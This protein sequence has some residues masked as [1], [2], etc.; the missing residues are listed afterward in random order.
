MVIGIISAPSVKWTEKTLET[1][2]FV[3]NGG[4][5]GDFTLTRGSCVW[6][7]LRQ[8]YVSFKFILP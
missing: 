3:G 5:T 1:G 8:Y 7:W 6:S 4:S 2:F